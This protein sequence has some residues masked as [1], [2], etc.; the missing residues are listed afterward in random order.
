MMANDTPELEDNMFVEEGFSYFEF[1]NKGCRTSRGEK[2][3]AGSDYDLYKNMPLWQCK[4]KCMRMDNSKF[5][6]GLCY[7]YEHDSSSNKCEV[8]KDFIDMNRLEYVRGLDCYI[9]PFQAMVLEE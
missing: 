4:E 9:K 6:G 7:G 2:G 8:W 1:E 3:R 5:T